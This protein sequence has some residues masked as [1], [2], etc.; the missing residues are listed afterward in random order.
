MPPGLLLLFNPNQ[1][2][3]DHFQTHQR[4][5]VQELEEVHAQG[6]AVEHLAL[7]G[8]EPLLHKDQAVR[9]FE[10]ARR[11]Y[12]KAHTRLYTCGD[13]LDEETAAALAGAGLQEVRFSLRMH[14][15]AGGKAHTLKRLALARQ[16]F[17]SV[18][19]EM[20]V[21]PGT[22]EEMES[23]LRAFDA[24][25]V[26]SIN[27]LEFCFPLGNAEAFHQKGFQI[28]NRPFLVLYDYW[29]AGGLPIAGSELVCLDLVAFALE[30]ELKMGVHYCSLENK[31]TGQLFQLNAGHS[32]PRTAYFS[33]RDFFIKSAKVFGEDIPP[34]QNHLEQAGYRHYQLNTDYNYLEFH[35]DKI[36]SLKKLNVEVGICYQVLEERQGEPVLRELKVDLTT[37]STFNLAKDI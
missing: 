35:V 9:F 16:H 23:L 2:N 5:L 28:K 21:L 29:Y 37:P 20:P 24:L 34:V 13:H 32:L 14:D 22:R 6:L 4:D 1:E 19:V 7:T 31:H 30:E 36:R 15:T 10:T 26:D 8:G 33:R 12:P 25:G 27:L 17:P 18:M 3:Y 11:L